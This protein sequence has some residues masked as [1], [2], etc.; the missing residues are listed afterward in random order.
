MGSTTAGLAFTLGNQ[1]ESVTN[2]GQCPGDCGL[3]SRQ[4]KQWAQA[5]LTFTATDA[6]ELLTIMGTG[7]PSPLPPV[8]LLT[9]VSLEQVSAPEP[10]TWLLLGISFAA[11]FGFAWWRRRVH[12]PDQAEQA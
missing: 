3:G 8:A 6:D 7:M 9:D 5:T 12:V 2:G 11:L 4:F 1:T 10:S